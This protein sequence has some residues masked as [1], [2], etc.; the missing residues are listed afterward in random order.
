MKNLW[1][2]P[3]LSSVMIIKNSG[4]F[5]QCTSNTKI[6]QLHLL[7]QQ[8]NCFECKNK[9]IALKLGLNMKFPMFGPILKRQQWKHKKEDS[10]IWLKNQ[11]MVVFD[12]LMRILRYYSLWVTNLLYN[13]SLK[14]MGQGWLSHKKPI[15]KLYSGFHL[16]LAPFAKEL[17]KE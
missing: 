11:R 15:D 1:F 7:Q 12:I 14:S 6:W 8:N 3:W 17:K 10:K 16:N 13:W 9:A 4:D 2:F 5:N